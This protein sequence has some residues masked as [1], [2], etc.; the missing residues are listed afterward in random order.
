ME[1]EQPGSVDAGAMH[2]KK[3]A[4]S[5]G[6]TYDVQVT[7]L[8]GTAFTVKLKSKKAKV[9]HLKSAVEKIHGTAPE[10]QEIFEYMEKP[11]QRKEAEEEEEEEEAMQL[12]D[13]ELVSPIASVVLYV[14]TVNWA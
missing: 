10:C 8:T 9:H 5:A 13:A 14:K 7:T 1:E 2:E 3:R 6:K 12:Q 4:P 11:K